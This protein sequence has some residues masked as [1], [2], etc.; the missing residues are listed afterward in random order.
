MKMI[1]AIVC[2]GVFKLFN[3]PLTWSNILLFGVGM[4]IAKLVAIGVDVIT[5][6][7]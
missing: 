4:G 1:K 6:R 3:I 2:L 5:D 7:N